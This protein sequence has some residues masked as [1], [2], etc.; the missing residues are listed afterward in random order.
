MVGSE[1]L[2][3][4]RKKVRLWAYVGLAAPGQQEPWP[5]KIL[6]VIRANVK[7]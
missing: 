1:G 5:R 3:G 2:L 6:V 7:M 4:D